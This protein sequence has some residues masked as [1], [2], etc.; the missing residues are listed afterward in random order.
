MVKSISGFV[1]IL[2]FNKPKWFKHF[3]M[4]TNKCYAVY[5]VR[6]CRLIPALKKYILNKS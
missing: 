2:F 6:C 4:N 1:I 3:T 5:H